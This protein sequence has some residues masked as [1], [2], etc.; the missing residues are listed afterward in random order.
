[1]VTEAPDNT[2][3]PVDV[4]LPLISTFAAGAAVRVYDVEGMAATNLITIKKHADDGGATVATLDATDE[5]A[6]FVVELGDWAQKGTWP[7]VSAAATEYATIKAL[8]AAHSASP[9]DDGTAWFIAD[10]DGSGEPMYGSVTA[11][12]LTPDPVRAWLDRGERS[13]PIARRV[14]RPV[15]L[16]IESS[17]T[18][19]L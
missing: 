10:V 7:V 9:L 5:E 1:M 14:R 12:E 15:T 3:G 18:D 19:W 13:L 8:L 4:T 17:G 6:W 2:L 16:D 11:G